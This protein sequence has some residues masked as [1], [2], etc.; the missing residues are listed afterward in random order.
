ML[1]CVRPFAAAVTCRWPVWEFAERVQFN[2]ACSRRIHD[3]VFPIPVSCPLRHTLRLTF[4]HSHGPCSGTTSPQ[5]EPDRFRLSPS[6][7]RRCAHLVSEGDD[8]QH[9]RLAGKHARKPRICC[10]PLRIAQRTAA[11]A[12]MISSPRKVRSPIR[13]VSPSFCLPPVERCSG[14]S[15]S[16][17]AKSRPLL[18]A[19]AVGARATSAVAVIGPNSWD[20]H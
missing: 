14:V 1:T 6:M 7:P 2:F 9:G 11:L 5:P 13:D 20:R 15:P 18:K 17:A 10:L 16:H 19:W 3:L 8:R 4:S 12:P